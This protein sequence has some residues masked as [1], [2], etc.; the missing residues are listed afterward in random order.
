MC[1]VFTGCSDS[2][3]Q[4]NEQP[5]FNLPADTVKIYKINQV[6]LTQ[7][8]IAKYVFKEID[9]IKGGISD[10]IPYQEWI[11]VFSQKHPCIYKLNQ[12]YELLDEYIIEGNGPGEVHFITS[13]T[14]NNKIIYV[15]DATTRKIVKLSID[16]KFIDETIV[17]EPFL[18]YNITGIV[19]LDSS[20]LILAAGISEDE[21]KNYQNREPYDNLYLCDMFN[22]KLLHSIS[23]MPDNI[24]EGI[25]ELDVISSTVSSPFYLSFF[26]KDFYLFNRSSNEI[27]ELSI[28]GDKITPIRRLVL[29]ENLFKFHIPMLLQDYND[30]N[31]PEKSLSWFRSGD[32]LDKV[33]LNDQLIIVRKT[34]YDARQDKMKFTYLVVDKNNMRLINAIY[35][36][37]NLLLN[38]LDE[39][40]LILSKY[41]KRDES[42]GVYHAQFIKIDLD[43][44][45]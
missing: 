11:F 27:I 8:V 39:K 10:V 29:P 2:K 34:S 14:V 25:V 4:K 20:N 16:G 41:I 7:S 19:S 21:W 26:K 15:T 1:I 28:Q 24:K 42:S 22:K 45:L 40:Y 30:F 17:T 35:S 3:P 18:P 23:C 43:D 6:E 31:N 9:F 44:L 37:E 32:N 33:C 36:Y 5:T 38:F 13:A 12:Q